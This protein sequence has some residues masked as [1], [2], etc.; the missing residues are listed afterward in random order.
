MAAPFKLAPKDTV[1]TPNGVLAT[2]T[3]VEG[4]QVHVSWYDNANWC[5]QS[6]TFHIRRLR[7]VHEPAI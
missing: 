7:R 5:Y 4:S 1:C 3:K 6:A 2:V